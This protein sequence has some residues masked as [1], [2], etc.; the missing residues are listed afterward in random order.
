MQ[1]KRR[2]VS[3]ALAVVVSLGAAGC[4]AGEGAKPDAFG[5]EAAQSEIRTV[6]AGAGL[7]ESAL[8]EP[9]EATGTVAPATERE[10]V[11][12]RAADCSAAWQYAGPVMDGGRG[13][14]DKALDAFVAAGWTESGKR[15]EEELGE[16]IGTTRGALLKKEG[17]SL[18]ARYS[19]SRQALSM[20][21]MG[22]TATEDTCMEQFTEQEMDLLS[23]GDA[24]P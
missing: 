11:A 2:A 5:R 15:W 1:G 19:T 22:F 20:D 3:A 23:G 24:A 13:K 9:G 10:R 18:S 21:V 7:P 12:R 14:Y 17:W 6:V 4:G 16:D 8:P